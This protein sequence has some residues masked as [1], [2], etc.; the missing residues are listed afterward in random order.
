MALELLSGTIDRIVSK[1]DF[2]DD[3]LETAIENQAAQIASL[4]SSVVEIEAHC[5]RLGLDPLKVTNA[6]RGI[7]EQ[8]GE[9][10]PS[11]TADRKAAIKA[12]IF[13]LVTDADTELEGAIERYFAAALELETGYAALN[14][15]FSEQ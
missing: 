6:V 3:M 11:P 4:T 7:A 5:A 9:A 10:F 8:F 1:I 14:Q 15:L 13:E 2:A 12:L